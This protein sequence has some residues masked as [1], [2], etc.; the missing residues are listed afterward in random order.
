MRDSSFGEWLAAGGERRSRPRSQ[1]TEADLAKRGQGASPESAL[2][3]LQPALV[4][5]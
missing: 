4:R 5:R 2:D 1:T 3:R